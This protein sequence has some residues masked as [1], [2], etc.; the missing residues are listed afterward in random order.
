MD[1]FYRMLRERKGTPKTSQPSIG[2]FEDAYRQL[3]AEADGIVS[4]HLSTKISGT[5]NS[6]RLAAENVAPDRIAIVDSQMLSD[7]VGKS[8][9]SALP[10]RLAMAPV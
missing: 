2:R 1:E 4:V 5:I 6:A 8:L 9:R 7:P 3:L 10:G